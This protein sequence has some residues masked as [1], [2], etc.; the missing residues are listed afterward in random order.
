MEANLGKPWNLVVTCRPEGMRGAIDRL[1][2]FGRFYRTGFYDVF[3]G[4]VEDREGF[5]ETLRLARE[6][7]DPI[8]RYIARMVP[9]DRTFFFT[10]ASFQERL[11]EVIDAMGPDVPDG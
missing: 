3:I 4:H 2:Y 11:G 10:V 5:F 1:K 9:I 6:R 8:W 7:E